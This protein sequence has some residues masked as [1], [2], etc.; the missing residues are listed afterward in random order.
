MDKELLF[1]KIEIL[2]ELILIEIK[3]IN[4]TFFQQKPTVQIYFRKKHLIGISL[5]D[6]IN[7]K[8]KIEVVEKP[9]KGKFHFFMYLSQ[10]EQGRIPKDYISN[11]ID[12]ILKE[13][14]EIDAY[15]LNLNRVKKLIKDGHYTVGIVFLISAFENA[16]RDLFFR[17]S[18][19]WFYFQDLI[20]YD[21]EEI[22]KKYIKTI[23]DK[24]DLDTYWMITENGNKKIGV[25][26]EDFEKYEQWAKINFWKYIFDTCKAL[27]VL[28]EYQLCLMSNNMKE[29]GKFEILKDILQK[30]I[31]KHSV[32]NFQSIDYKGGLKWCFKRFYSIGFH[33]IPSEIKFINEALK[34]RHKII[35]G[36]MDYDE[37]DKEYI[38]NLLGTIERLIDYL[39]DSIFYLYQD[40]V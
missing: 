33:E 30:S 24:E 19:V 20:S 10:F 11:I 34:K 25:T 31:G 18:N 35:H 14:Q 23:E 16:V 7:P 39:R 12:N 4:L 9:K 21:S 6:E 2:I 22:E 28:D 5:L 8:I 1:R 13:K 36:F 37:T 15:N 3:E 26:N 38:V 27:K 32:M 29:I 17:Y 40:L